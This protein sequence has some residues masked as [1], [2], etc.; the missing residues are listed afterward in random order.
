LSQ[1]LVKYTPAAEGSLEN[2][3]KRIKMAGVFA[4]AF[5]GF[6]PNEM[7]TDTPEEALQGTL[8]GARAVRVTFE[9]LEN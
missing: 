7:W 4:A 2:V 3:V 6:K 9:F 8:D 1:K 5:V